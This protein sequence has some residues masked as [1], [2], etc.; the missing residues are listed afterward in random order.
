MASGGSDIDPRIDMNK[1]LDDG[2]VKLMESMLWAT[3][4][5]YIIPI[6]EAEEENYEEV[7]EEEEHYD[8]S[9]PSGQIPATSTPIGTVP[10]SYSA[11]PPSYR[12]VG[13]P[14]PRPNSLRVHDQDIS[15]QNQDILPQ[16]HDN[17]SQQPSE[18]PPATH[19]N[20]GQYIMPAPMTSFGRTPLSAIGETTENI[21]QYE[22][23]PPPRPPQPNVTFGGSQYEQMPPS[24]PPEPNV[25]FGG[26][27][28]EQMPPSY[29]SRQ[30]VTFDS[31]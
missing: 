24:R 14:T 2:D 21:P 18:I 1:L 8:L 10:R 9:G 23:L 7:E 16:V 29:P 22:Q 6:Y 11:Q 30:N 4:K 27:R 19:D 12:P 17:L 28:Y 15:S 3:G 25:T 5:F 31:S 26:P 13:P 20:L